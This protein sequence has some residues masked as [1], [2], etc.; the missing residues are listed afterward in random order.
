MSV[1]ACTDNSHRIHVMLVDGNQTFLRAA[2]NLLERH[3]E[4][5][6][7]GTFSE[8][9]KALAQ[10]Q[11]LRPQVI[12]VG[13]DTPVMMGLDAVSRLRMRLPEVAIIA[14]TMLSDNACRRAALFAGAD[15]VVTKAR[16]STDLVPAIRR[17]TEDDQS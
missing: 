7:V 10:A 4:L 2:I 13:L 15:E 11:S 8:S 17:V 5:V 16:L 9:E 12:M 14:L 6:I 3:P 1:R